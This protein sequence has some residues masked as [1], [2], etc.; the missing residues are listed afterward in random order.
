MA[1]TPA[2][3]CLY[4]GIKM[5]KTA[6]ILAAFP[7]GV[8]I[9]KQ[10]CLDALAEEMWGIPAPKAYD[11]NHFD[12]IAAF[13]KTLTRAHLAVLW[14]DA[15]I[16]ADRTVLHLRETDFKG[17]KQTQ[18]LYMK[19]YNDGLR[20]RDTLRD[21]GIHAFLTAHAKPAWTDNGVRQK[22]VP[23]F[24][25]QTATKFPGAFDIL[26]RCEMKPAGGLGWGVCYRTSLHPDWE[27]GT[28]YNVPDMAPMN[29]G[30]IL[31][32]AGF[33]IPRYP[34]LEWQDGVANQLANKLLEAP[35]LGDA[36]HVKG[37][38]LKTIDACKSKGLTNQ[39][40]V[41]WAVRDGY[42]RAVLKT[43]AEAHQRR[44]WGI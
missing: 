8:Y 24:P 9:A 33:V 12:E 30:E 23:A 39:K 43:A 37:W 32:A 18:A 6:D 14:D 15:T 35:G 13:A 11:Y 38:I 29:L 21:V 1:K 16:S 17:D 31:R 40:H 27:Q 3:G 25:G 10:A 19:L 42:D 7:Q 2:F 4:G 41:L 34:G 28:R 26:M 22:G 36:E 5:G 20:I 44:L